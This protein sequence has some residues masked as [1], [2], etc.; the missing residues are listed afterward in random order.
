MNIGI[1]T[2]APKWFILLCLLA[3]GVYAAVLYF[4]DK[5]LSEAPAW[6]KRTMTALRFLVVS[7]VAFLL[8]S[9]LLK[10]TSREVRKPIIVIAQDESESIIRSKDSAFY[11]TE[12]RTQLEKTIAALSE[13]FEVRTYS[14]GEKFR[15]S[16]SYTFGD[17]ET[18]ISTLFG[19]I[20]NRFS[21]RN[22][23]AIII[24][25]DGLYNKGFSPVSAAS[26]VKVPVFA[27]GLGDTTLR[28]DLVLKNVIHN[29]I[30]YLGNTFPLE[31]VIE[32]KRCKGAA[33]TLTV[34]K[35]GV[36]LFTQQVPVNADLFSMSIPVQLEAKEAGLQR[37]R[38]ALSP[39]DGEVTE[40]NNVIDIYID[41]LD[42]REKIL[43]LSA[44]PHPD[45][46]ALKESIEA[47]DNY[48]V[49]SFAISD[50]DQPVKNY[51]MVILHSLPSAENNVQRILT[52]LESGNIPVWYITGAQESYT[53]FNRLQ[54]GLNITSS[55]S[56]NNDVE[57]IPAPNFPLFTLSDKL[58]GYVPRF[59]ALAVPFG[60]LSAANSSTVLFSQKIGSLKTNYPLWVFGQQGERKTAV[61]AGEGLWRWKLRDFADHQN[62]D[63]FNELVSKTVQYLSVKVDKSFFR[64]NTKTNYPEN[65]PVL[66][67]AEVYNDS[68]ELINE[69]EVSINIVDAT[70]K[71][72]PFTFSKTGNA[73]RL[74]AG[75]FPA[76]EY[77]YEARVKVGQKIFTQNGRF[78]VSKL[79]AEMTSTTADHQV[80]YSLAK[81]HQGELL[82]VSQL[83]ELTTRLLAREDIKPVIY[84]PKRLEDFINL[85]WLFFVL[86]GMLTLEWFLRKRFGAY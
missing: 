14:F 52:D 17:K 35:N 39:V 74:N 27:I 72:F 2:E 47:N 8:L 64:I 81:Q 32:A 53:A 70:E 26:R 82:Q 12:Y 61:L 38:V 5:R 31:A 86:L 41:V 68:Y 9:P 80:L 22:L 42:G 78:S 40:A 49:E 59:P 21:G 73:Y 46:A 25:S 44:A 23:G 33:T 62:H 3:G 50:F 75:R 58:Q 63:L 19:E 55:G 1:V 56:R 20:E 77:R 18:D 4:R 6:I 69:P 48:E 45:V 85:K 36:K 28:R 76:G 51:N 57:A 11:K 66:L 71:R 43:I 10:M 84:N 29:R 67:D 7:V 34:S 83:G 30:A 79:I 13:K 15:E 24:A 60:T 54:A 65:E 37:Y 16:I